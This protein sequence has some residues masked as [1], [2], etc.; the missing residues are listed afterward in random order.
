MRF[1]PLWITV[2][3]A[4]LAAQDID[5]AVMPR[6]S[7]PLTIL[8]QIRDRRERAAFVKL[9]REKQPGK[10]RVLA[11][12]FLNRW[13]KSWLLAT[14]YEIASKASIDLNDYPAAILYGNQSLRL[15]PEN[16]LLLVPLAD[17]EG[18][19]KQLREAKESARLALECL[20]RFNRPAA[21]G[22]AEWPDVERRLRASSY[23]VLGR[24][25]SEEA[26]SASDAARETL[27][28]EAVMQLRRAQRQDPGDRETARLLAIA[29]K[30]L[31][32]T[33]G[34]ASRQVPSENF[35]P[36]GRAPGAGHYAGSESCRKCHA[37]IH[38]AWQ[39]T[40]MARMFRAYDPENVIGRFG[41]HLSFHGDD[42]KPE[43]WMWIEN[44]RHYLGA[45]GLEGDLQ[46]Y[47][48]DY[49]IGSK[50]QQAY[51]TRL[52]DGRIQVFPLQYNKL[53]N[54]WLNYWKVI[55]PPG[56]ERTNVNGFYHM[57]RATNYQLNC[58]PCHTSQLA[59]DPGSNEPQDMAFR[60]PGINC[61]MCHGPSADHVSAM[62]EGKP[63]PKRASDPPVDFPKLDHRA[64]VAICA[65]C[66]MQSAV[67]EQGRH[68]EWNYS[69]SAESFV[70]RYK[71]RPLAEF[72]GRAFYKDGRFRETTF[73][74]EALM[75]SACYRRGEVHCGNCHDPHPQDAPDNPTSLKFRTDS[76]QMCLQCHAGYSAHLE[77]HTHHRAS[78]EGS[79]CVNC[80]MPRIMNSLLFLARTHQID[81]KPRAESTLRFGQQESPN[82]CLLCHREKDAPWVAQ[83][84][85][86]W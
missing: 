61:E 74:V 84:L 33:G 12:D 44:G 45:K 27:W 29:E 63:Y 64:Y 58:A 11:E 7:R 1:T 54:K 41:N 47:R 56:S 86:S 50:W 40:G 67:R 51:A 77:R 49:T 35:S 26:L 65:Q 79:R 14:V 23:F 78:S 20:D 32:Q 71:E 53:E 37:A 72:S 76:D 31:N 9:Y 39:R 28:H 52:A 57:S 34:G 69:S 55:D 59:S 60:E 83:Q 2:L 48:V 21:I 80:H 38:A 13:P 62:T 18:K 22:E 15:L 10:R 25:A 19:E 46:K 85:Q 43:A 36:S 17:V 8:D 75:R 42:G 16:P 66:H 30:S 81:D 82:A 5:V 4:I 24:A 73:I 70:A 68:G 6:E 3:A